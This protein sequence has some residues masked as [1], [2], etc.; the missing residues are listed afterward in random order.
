MHM[1]FT[2]TVLA[3]VQTLAQSVEIWLVFH[4]A[5][6]TAEPSHQAR[7]FFSGRYGHLIVQEPLPFF[8]WNNPAA[9]TFPSSQ[10]IIQKKV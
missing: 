6:K 9:L 4:H 1:P 7:L 8:L 10:N 5:G 3:L 2:H